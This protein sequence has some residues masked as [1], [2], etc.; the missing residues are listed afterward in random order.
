[1]K[2]QQ[3]WEKDFPWLQYDENYQGAFC[4]RMTETQS[5]TL[6]GSGGVW[7]AKPFQNWKKAI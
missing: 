1:M 4:K 5:Q 6:Q 3:K 7:V 2:I